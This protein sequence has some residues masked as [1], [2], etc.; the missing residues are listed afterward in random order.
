MVGDPGR[1]SGAIDAPSPT[2]S[3]RGV[4]LAGAGELQ[5]PRTWVAQ[6]L[7]LGLAGDDLGHERWQLH[8]RACAAQRREC[9]RTL[10]GG[11]RS[12]DGD[13]L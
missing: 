10:G 9:S 8:R 2:P 6:S 1:G 5:L 13:S 4:D 11:G 12:G 3:G 7:A